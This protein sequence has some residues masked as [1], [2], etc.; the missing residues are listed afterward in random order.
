MLTRPEQTSDIK[1]VGLKTVTGT[2]RSINLLLS[3]S[4]HVPVYGAAC[5]SS[6]AGILY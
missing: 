2:K 4:T 6:A 3:F 1:A 5:I